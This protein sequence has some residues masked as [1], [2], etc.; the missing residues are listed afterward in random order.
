MIAGFGDQGTEDILDQVNSPAARRACPQ[1]L[2][3]VARR[4]LDALNRAGELRDLSQIPG[5][6]L[7]ALRGDRAG[8][9]SIRI[10][11]RY[12]ICFVWQPRA[13]TAVEITPYH[14]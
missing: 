4:K 12:R 2:W 10:N 8:Q 3:P 9:Y 13:A 14:G 6:R 1:Q 7:E 5:N 11:E